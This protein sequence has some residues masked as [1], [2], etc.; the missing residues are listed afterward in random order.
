MGFDLENKNP[1]AKKLL[2]F[3]VIRSSF[4]STNTHFFGVVSD[5]SFPLLILICV[6]APLRIWFAKTF[7]LEH[8]NFIVFEFFAVVFL[9]TVVFFMISC[10]LFNRTCE[11]SKALK[12]LSFAQEKV[13][14]YL[15]EGLKAFAIIMAGLICFIIPGLIKAVHYIFVGFVV[16]FDPDYEAG[17]LSALKRSKELSKGLSWW[18]FSL[19]VLIQFPFY[20]C[21]T[22][23]KQPILQIDSL[24]VA[25]PVFVL[26]TYAEM[27][28][29]IF[30]YSILYFMYVIQQKNYIETKNK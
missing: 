4:F 8:F 13:G 27:L 18:I 20:V 15:W 30:L 17:K 5:I 21:T 11:E 7:G 6:L 22:A 1:S 28:I 24:W 3:D 25:S 14:L 19:V 29:Y 9:W 23:V 26:Q 16:F 2:G 12:L 10:S